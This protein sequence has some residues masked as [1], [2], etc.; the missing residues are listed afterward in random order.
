MKPEHP[1]TA[2]PEAARIHFGR[3]YEVHHN[4][5]VRPL[6]LIY[7]GSMEYL[8]KQFESNCPRKES[9][10]INE[11]KHTMEDRQIVQGLAKK[12]KANHPREESGN[13]NEIGHIE[14]ETCRYASCL[15]DAS[16]YHVCSR[17]G[18]ITLEASTA[19]DRL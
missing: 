14:G 4:I 2:L 15:G 12:L 5:A 16:N 7:A 6:G 18:F 17:A 10:D 19:R 9:S 8:M 3:A 1:S 11:K 13:G